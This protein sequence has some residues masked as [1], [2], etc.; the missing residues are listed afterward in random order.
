MTLADHDINRLITLLKGVDSDPTVSLEPSS[1][2]IND[3]IDL[4][5]LYLTVGPEVHS[6]RER[7]RKAGYPVFPGEV[8][9]FGWLTAY[10]QMKRGIIL[11]G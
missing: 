8:D 1:N 9:R 4:A 11:F 2:S 7:L 3:I 5:T 10:F 6:Y